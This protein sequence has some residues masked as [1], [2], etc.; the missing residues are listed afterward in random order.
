MTKPADQ[1]NDEALQ[2]LLVADNT[3]FLHI[4]SKVLNR[5]VEI[6]VVGIV[7]DC[8]QTVEQAKTLALRIILIDLDMSGDNGIEVL[9]CIHKTLPA[10]P[11]IALSLLDASVILKAAVDAGANEFVHKLAINSELMPACWRVTHPSAP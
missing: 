3:S 10:I 7:R 8:E 2:I 4:V 5:H 9:N 1:G 6:V 11:I